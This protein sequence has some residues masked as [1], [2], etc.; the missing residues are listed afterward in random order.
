MAIKTKEEY[1]ER[2]RGMNHEIFIKGD[3]FQGSFVDS[4]YARSTRNVIEL[5]YDLANDPKWANEFTSFSSLVEEKVSWWNAIPQTTDDLLQLVRNIKNITSK[6][7]CA[8]CMSLALDV[9]WAITH[10]IDKEKGTKYHQNVKNFFKE[11]QKGDLRF[12][13][14]VMDV[15]GDRGLKPNQQPD[16]DMHL[17]IVKKNDKGMIV[18]GCKGQVSGGPL[19]DKI[20][21]IPCR[22]YDAD[23]KDFVVSF[24]LPTD[25]P[26]IKYII[27]P[28][29]GPIEKREIS[30]PVS[31]EFGWIECFTVFED[32]FVPWENVFMCGEWDY[33]DRFMNYFSSFVRIL[34]T[35]C[36]SART[37][38]FIGASALVAQVNGIEKAGHVR[39]K[40]TD[41]MTSSVIGYGCALAA[42][43]ESKAHPSGI[44]IPDIAIGNA[45]LYETRLKLQQSFGTLMDLSGGVITT[46]PLEAD[47]QNPETRGYM[48]KY[49]KGKANIST[50]ERIRALSLA[51][52]L[53]ASNFSGYFMSSVLCAGGTPETNRVEVYR[54]YD[55]ASK[56][57]VARAHAKIDGSV[58]EQ[59]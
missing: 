55:L 51:Q 56:I 6:K 34:K 26:G 52:D 8:F 35:V 46:M 1:A 29:A 39:S 28:P 30:N 23:E 7:Y 50:E 54:N 40:L 32:V 16:Q 27:R 59:G 45:G 20:V 36:C 44:M 2:L 18:R 41:M 37:D 3:R 11:I 17:H 22:A 47:Y 19:T 31:S 14:G 15:K 58:F 33:T 48:E 13:M 38:I 12:C 9:V 25:T 5:G 53:V 24:A 21:V 49:L 4:P 10:E 42:A 43:V 57:K